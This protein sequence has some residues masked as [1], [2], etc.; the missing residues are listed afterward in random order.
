MEVVVYGSEVSCNVVTVGIK[1]PLPMRESKRDCSRGNT[2]C[3]NPVSMGCNRF[4]RL[5]GSE[6]KLKLSEGLDGAVVS[7]C[8]EGTGEDSVEVDGFP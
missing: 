2:P 8:G 7:G 3:G 1:F 4:R 5:G 6:E